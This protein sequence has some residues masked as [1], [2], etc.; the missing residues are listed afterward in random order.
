MKSLIQIVF[1]LLILLFSGASF[2]QEKTKLSELKADLAQMKTPTSSTEAQAY[3]DLL[4]KIGL[5]YRFV[6][7]DSLN[8]YTEM[9]QLTLDRQKNKNALSQALIFRNKGYYYSENGES[10]KALEYYNKTLDISKQQ[11]FTNLKLKSYIWMSDE[12]YYLD[13]KGNELTSL[14][15]VIDEG[16]KD[17]ANCLL[18]LSIATENIAF[19]YADQEEF[20]KALDYFK[21]VLS[22]NKE[23]N[24]DESKAQSYTN[25]ADT[26]SEMGD[27]TQAQH[28]I[29]LAIAIF[30]EKGNA[31][32]LATAYQIKG[33]IF[34]ESD[35]FEQSLKYI[36]KAKEL[37][38][39][40]DDE[41]LRISLLLDHA[42]VLYRLGQLEEAQKKVQQASQSK[43]TS[44]D[45]QLKQECL[46]LLFEI[47]KA[48]GESESALTYLEDYRSLSDS[49]LRVQK[50]NRI[51]MLF[52]QLKFEDEKQ[53]IVQTN[54]EIAS[55]Q[56]N[57]LTLALAVAAVLLV[58]L[59][60]LYFKQKRLNVLNSNL[61]EREK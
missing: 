40:I 26:L 23:L 5:K 45:V 24:K 17:R 18:E 54:R 28:Y 50:A 59:I 27:F 33:L 48:K 36:L 51:D 57:Q 34:Y 7:N 31:V 9:A 58:T 29:D 43:L 37:L 49:I 20:E 25:L 56:K 35:Q 46:E 1:L 4:I 3:I 16:E 41:R 60:P 61:Q 30:E 2:G 52:A 8:H 10:Q 12:Y 47:N 11:G 32:W 14:L 55:R 6:D 38:G 13:Q 42:Y 22:Y 21:K 44:K 19:L 15:K 53:A 39:S